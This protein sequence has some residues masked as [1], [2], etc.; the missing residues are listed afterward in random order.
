MKLKNILFRITH[1]ETW[2]FHAKYL[3]LSPAWLWYCLRSGSFWF[4]T[5][6]NPTLT[7]GGF[8][9]ETKSEMYAQLPPN[10]YPK[11]IFISP[12]L[13]DEKLNALVIANEFQY[14]FIVKPDAGMMGFMF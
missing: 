5:P 10:S 3:P 9:G 12:D 1:W 11:S 2:H 4:F 6:S 8:E 14:P 13:S 7:F